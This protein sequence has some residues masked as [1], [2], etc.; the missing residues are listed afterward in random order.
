MLGHCNAAQSGPQWN[1]AQDLAINSMLEDEDRNSA[2]CTMPR[3]K[4][5]DRLGL[6]PA[7]FDFPE[8]ETTETYYR[9]L[10]QALKEIPK[11]RMDAH[12]Q[13]QEAEGSVEKA[14]ALQALQ[15]FAHSL[16]DRL[17]KSGG[18]GNCAGDYL[19]RIRKA[20]N[21]KVPWHRVLKRHLGRFVSEARVADP[22]KPSRR[23]GFPWLGTSPQLV[24][25]VDLYVDTSASVGTKELEQFVSE[26]VAA[27]RVIPVFLHWFD[28]QVH[29]PA[30]RVKN[31]IDSV[32]AKGRGGTSFQ[33]MINHAEANHYRQVVCLTDGECSA[34]KLH[35]N[36]RLVWVIS[37]PR[38]RFRRYWGDEIDEL[39]GTVIE[40]E[41]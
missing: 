8:L 29:E 7:D 4:H 22:R 3:D 40:I 30:I 18:W 19:E 35:Q 38:G 2:Y 32:H 16:Y 25:R 1:A 12:I 33:A 14:A 9:L 37:R 31:G 39:P 23:F 10:D 5:G 28:T 11:S 13:V 24:G 36:M 15:D 34:P 41:V 17:E 26:A 20:Q 27:A 21:P 6:H